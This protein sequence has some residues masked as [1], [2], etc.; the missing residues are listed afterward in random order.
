VKRI[1]AAAV[2]AVVIVPPMLVA[3]SVV[4]LAQHYDNDW[5]GR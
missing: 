2:V 3:L 1:A 5:S 4:W